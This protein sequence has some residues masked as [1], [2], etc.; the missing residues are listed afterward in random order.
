MY[1]VYV[2]DNSF[3]FFLISNKNHINREEKNENSKYKVF[4]MVNTRNSSKNNK[5]KK[6][7]LRGNTKGSKKLQSR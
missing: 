3:F 4:M 5:D 6:S 7:N 2:Y 1:N